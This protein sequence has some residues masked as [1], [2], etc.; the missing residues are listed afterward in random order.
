HDFDSFRPRDGL[1]SL[2][3]NLT[4]PENCEDGNISNIDSCKNNCEYAQ[5]GDAWEQNTYRTDNLDVDFYWH[6]G[7]YYGKASWLENDFRPEYGDNDWENTID[8]PG[9]WDTGDDVGS[10]YE[11]VFLWSI[12]ETCDD[13]ND[14]WNDDCVKWC[15]VAECGDGWHNTAGAA[16]NLEECDDGDSNIYPWHADA[17]YDFADNLF[18][19]NNLGCLEDCTEARCGD[20]FVQYTWYHEFNDDD[21][22]QVI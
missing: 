14:L 1:C 16:A 11:S 17:D 2:S 8:G 21:Y 10:P 13:G 5:C 22:P 3:P 7:D 9:H 12:A 6:W 15:Q 4:G 20:G 18:N 19:H